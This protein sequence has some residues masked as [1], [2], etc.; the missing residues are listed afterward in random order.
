MTLYPT[1]AVERTMKVQEVIL[2]AAAKKITW[3][4]AAQILRISDRSMRRWK[5]RYEKYGYDGLID[6]RRQRPSPK[7]APMKEVE[8]ILTLYR[9]TYHGFN[10]RHYHEQLMEKHNVTLSYSFVK[11]A[12]QTAGLVARMTVRGRHRKRRERKDCFGEMMHIDGSPHEWL[13]LCPGEKQ[14]MIAVIDDATSR[15]LYG[16]L[17]EEEDTESIMKAL[18]FVFVK[19]G[20]PLML[21]CDRASW[22]FH[23]PVAGGKV[24]KL[25][26][27]QVGRALDRLGVEH[28][29]AYS[30]QA[31]GRSERLNR[32]TQDRVVNELRVAGIK[33]VQA[34]NRYLEEVY[35][36]NHNK[37][38]VVEP[39]APQSLFVSCKPMQLDQILCEEWDRVVGKDNVVRFDNLKLQIE[40]QSNLTTCAGRRVKVRYHLNHTI[41]IWLGPKSLGIYDSQGL[42]LNT[43]P[44]KE[45][46]A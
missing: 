38:F 36:P 23:T 40:K 39:K 19:Y 7:R 4:Q 9:E 10:V 21:Y 20:L 1:T 15:M 44:P 32:T 25:N 17:F 2:R 29:P 46:A 31:R 33:D 18:H 12:L 11:A 13:S 14:T 8:K 16:Q 42:A 6:R 43:K 37:R 45:K 28:Q 22:A 24:D 5:M 26:L 35:I 30:P 27:T 41:S 3:I 34:A